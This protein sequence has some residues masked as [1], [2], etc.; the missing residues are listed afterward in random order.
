MSCSR[1]NCSTQ[2][3]NY[4]R[5]VRPKEWLFPG[6]FAR[7]IT[8][9]AVEHACR[10]ARLRA[11]ISKPISPHSL[12]PSGRRLAMP[13]RRSRAARSSSMAREAGPATARS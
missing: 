12:K 3:R 8:T 10:Q 6:Y 4:W 5:I 13:A 9:H 2:L 1:R 11:G 7:P